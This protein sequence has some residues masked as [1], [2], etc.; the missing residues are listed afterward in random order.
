VDWVRLAGSL[1]ACNL[2]CDPR[3]ENKVLMPILFLIDRFHLD[4]VYK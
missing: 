1:V 4:H 3:Y 2:E